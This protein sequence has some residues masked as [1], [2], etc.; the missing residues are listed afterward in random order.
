MNQYG[1][2]LFSQSSYHNT[3][4]ETREQSRVYEQVAQAQDDKILALMNF[5][6]TWTADDI[7]RHF[8]NMLLTSIRRALTNLSK[9]GYI[10]ICGKKEGKYKRNVLVWRIIRKGESITKQ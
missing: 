2:D 4:G 1:P 9:A 6:A 5:A 7:H 3:A 10:E 8:P